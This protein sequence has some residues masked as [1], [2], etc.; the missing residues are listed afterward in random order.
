MIFLVTFLPA[1]QLI[2]VLLCF[3]GSSS[4]WS[5]SNKNSFSSFVFSK[6][7]LGSNSKLRVNLLVDSTFASTFF[8]CDNTFKSSSLIIL[9]TLHYT[10]THLLSNIEFARTLAQNSF[11]G[12]AFISVFFSSSFRC[13]SIS[14]I[15][16]FDG[17]L[18]PEMISFI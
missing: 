17:T 8:R 12:V 1:F 6:Y 14:L 16:Y 11:I 2:L 9:P 15:S 13:S 3:G 10:S 18:Y 7:S 5:F 4:S